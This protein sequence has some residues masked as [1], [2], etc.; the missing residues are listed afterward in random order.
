MGAAGRRR[1]RPDSPPQP[2]AT[3]PAPALFAGGGRVKR[4]RVLV[5]RF[6]EFPARRVRA[7]RERRDCSRGA[8]RRVVGGGRRRKPLPFMLSESP[9]TWL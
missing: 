7:A 5:S 8:P 6:V 2:S 1:A 4:A 9:S 3:T